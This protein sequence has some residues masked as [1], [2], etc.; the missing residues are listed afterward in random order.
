MS[1]QF[2]TQLEKVCLRRRR[3]HWLSVT[4]WAFAI[5]I[6]AMFGLIGLDYAINIQHRIGRLVLT[7][8]FVSCLGAIV[9]RGRGAL[10]KGSVTPLTVAHEVE[11]LYPE[12]KD[13]VSSA[14]D[15]CQQSSDDPTAGSESL[16]RAVIL[17]ADAAAAE[18]DWSQLVSSKR[19]SKAAG[20]L[21]VVALLAGGM[22]GWQPE[23]VRVGLARLAGSSS[24]VEWP[25]NHDLQ[26]IQP[27]ALLAAGDD[28]VLRLRDTRKGLP[29]AVTMHYRTRLQGHWQEKT[30]TFATTKNLLEIRRQNVLESLQYR[31]T[32]GDHPTMAWQSLEVV[33][34]PRVE[35]LQVTVYPPAYMRLPLHLWNE[36]TSIY[37]GSELALQGQTDQPVTQAMLV[38]KNGRQITAQ[39]GPEGRHL[40]IEHSDWQINKRD[41]YVLQLTTA[42][43]L[44]VRSPNELVF[45]VIADQPPQVRFLQPGSDLTLLPTVSVPLVIEANDELALKEI[46]LLFVRSDRSNKEK[47]RV[48][49]WKSTGQST[50]KSTVDLNEKSTSKKQVVDF[51]WPLKPLRLPPGCVLEVHAQAT[52]NQPATGKSL[53]TLRL[54]IV[55]EDELWHQILRKQTRLV[56]RIVRLLRD[57]RELHGTTTSWTELPDW[58]MSRWANAAHASLFRQRQIRETIDGGQQSIVRQLA[59]LLAAID[60]N[61][62]LRPEVADRLLAV[63]SVLQD[64]HEDSLATIEQSLSEIVRQAQQSQERKSLLP[65]ITTI[66]EQQEQVVAGLRYAIDML[67]PGNVLGRLERE[68]T[69]LETDQQDL[70]QRCRKELTPQMLFEENKKPAALADVIRQQREI[71]R[72]MAELL[73]SMTQAAERLTEEG[74]LFASRLNETVLLAD[75]LGTQA[76]LQS[77]ANQLVRR[78]LGRASTLQEKVLEDLAKLKARLAGQDAASFVEQLKKLRSTEKKLQKLRR[79]VATI[80]Q[81]HHKTDPKDSER[82]AKQAEAIAANLEQ[83]RIPNAAKATED[84]ASRL[85]RAPPQIKKARQQIDLAQQLVTTARRRQQVA[86]ARLEMARLDAKIDSL[87]VRQQ[88]IQQEIE[89]NKRRE[90]KEQDFVTLAAS[91]SDLRT[92]VLAEAEQLTTLPVFAH[93][94]K[95]SAETM[96]RVEGQLQQAKLK[97]PKAELAEQAASQLTRLAKILRQERKKFSTKSS[98]RSDAGQGGARDKPQEQTLQLAIGQLKLL[99]I[100]QEKLQQQ[101]QTLRQKPH[102]ASELARQQK[103][104]TDLARQ[105]LSDTP[106]QEKTHE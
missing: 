41:T 15:F 56:D 9:A 3:S 32:G 102:L 25:R 52:D 33:A 20:A 43:G 69:A 2:I 40:R 47:H 93:L 1:Q 54:H 86:L 71:A 14:W 68:L 73:L 96:Q 50:G 36:N 81:E 35:Q 5:L 60:R 29:P 19:L 82:L 61:Q 48:S 24:N 75:D 10:L 92:E 53:R 78:R 44:I 67:M 85:R 94:L 70:L 31:A 106:G 4:C 89:H 51:L 28:L 57:Q 58:S 64:L 95:Q 101:T 42:A 62:L 105:L 104:L 30:Q 87:V 76:T 65:K 74:L 21:A 11:Q 22:I 6:V 8:L 18:V 88:A 13:F 83:L 91:Q 27:P 23:I 72:R 98:S 59:D 46:E 63:Q 7:T 79:Q 80:E 77:A 49:L 97:E 99:R 16:R 26:F 34:A 84:A 66:E 55:S 90:S 103:Q 12:S 45:E 37:S 38:S 100:L 39:V 17:R